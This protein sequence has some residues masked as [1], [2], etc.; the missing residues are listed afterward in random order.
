VDK[1]VNTMTIPVQ[2]KIKVVKI[3]VIKI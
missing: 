1:L 3:V 2:M